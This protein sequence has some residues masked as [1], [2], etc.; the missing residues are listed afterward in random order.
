MLTEIASTKAGWSVEPSSSS[1]SCLHRLLDKD[2][3]VQLYFDVKFQESTEASKEL[4]RKVHEKFAAKS[5]SVDVL[6]ETA[7]WEVLRRYDSNDTST[8]FGRNGQMTIMAFAAGAQLRDSAQLFIVTFE[9]E[10][11]ARPVLKRKKPA[12]KPSKSR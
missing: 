6:A 4:E 7:K 12:A 1:N 8:F 11:D 9:S 2:K 3:K 5:T 10:K